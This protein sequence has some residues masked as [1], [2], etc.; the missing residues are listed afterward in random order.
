MVEVVIVDYDPGWPRQFEAIAVRV[1]AAFDNN[2]LVAIEHIGSTSVPNL[3]AKPVIDL[4]VLVRSKAD[5]PNAIKTLA[6][7][8]YIHE[9]DKG[10]K[11]RE[12]FQWPCDMPRHHLYVCAQ[13]N[14][15]L[16][17]HVAFRDYLRTYPEDARRYGELKIELVARYHADRVAYNNAKTEFV[18]AVLEKIAP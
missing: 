4:D 10:I 15:E 13:G 7:L 2:N 1:R 14:A 16:Q 5:V 8:G 11:G 6:A 3:P 9:G 18:E 17:R 12:A